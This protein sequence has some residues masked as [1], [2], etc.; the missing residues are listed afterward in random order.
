[1]QRSCWRGIPALR[2][3]LLQVPLLPT[4]LRT[5]LPLRRS[6]SGALKAPPAQRIAVHMQAVH[7][8]LVCMC[9]ARCSGRT[10]EQAKLAVYTLQ[11]H[12]LV[13]TPV[14]RY[15]RRTGEQAGLAVHTLAMSSSVRVWITAARISRRAVGALQR[16]PQGRSASTCHVRGWLLLPSRAALAAACCSRLT[17]L[18]QGLVLRGRLLLRQGRVALSACCQSLQ[19]C[20]RAALAS[21]CPFGP[22]VEPSELTLAAES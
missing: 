2:C 19:P 10:G 20:R 7:P 11:V 14:A 18:C 16:V 8:L 15:L 9:V 5:G 6:Y 22:R 13:C 3:T 21:S 17:R 12:M 4:A 1:M